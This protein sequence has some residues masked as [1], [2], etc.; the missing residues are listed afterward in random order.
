MYIAFSRPY[1]D[2]YAYATV[3]R[4]SVVCNVCIVA[5]RCVLPKNSDEANRKWPIR[6]RIV[7]WPMTS[8]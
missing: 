3:L 8:H 4:P 5:K 6:N 7:T 2:S 1:T